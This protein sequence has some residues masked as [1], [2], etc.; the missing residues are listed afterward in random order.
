MVKKSVKEK[1]RKPNINDGAEVWKLIKRTEVLD[2]NSSYS[3][4]MWCSYFSDTS[5]VLEIDDRVVGFVSAFIKQSSPDTLFVWQIVVDETERGKG[6]ASKMLHHLLKRESCKGIKYIEAT[7]SPSNTQSIRLF[8]GLARKLNTHIKVTE[9]LKSADFPE[10]GHEEEL[11]HQI[12][13]F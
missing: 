12:G 4:L 6:L 9:F 8:E 1:F 10:D 3:Y 5:V 11:K 7:V 2:L 13:P